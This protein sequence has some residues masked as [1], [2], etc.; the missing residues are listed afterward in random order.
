[1]HCRPRRGDVG[2]HGLGI[3]EGDIFLLTGPPFCVL[4]QP[5]N[6]QLQFANKA[7]RPA[8]LGQHQLLHK[9]WPPTHLMSQALLSN[10]KKNRF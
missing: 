2:N 9:E 8:G 6:G 7:A 5:P 1:M 3:F 4:A 10:P